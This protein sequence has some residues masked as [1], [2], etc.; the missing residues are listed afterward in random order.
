[1]MCPN[2]PTSFEMK[3]HTILV[4]LGRGTNYFM[5]FAP[6]HFHFFLERALGELGFLADGCFL[7]IPSE[8]AQYESPALVPGL[9]L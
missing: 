1:M 5:L 4:G 2:D 6:L 3:F 9:I 7:A 8:R